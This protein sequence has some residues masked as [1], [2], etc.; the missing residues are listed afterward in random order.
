[1]SQFVTYEQTKYAAIRL[2]SQGP[3][4][5]GTAF[6]FIAGWSKL[7]TTLSTYPLQVIQNRLR[8]FKSKVNGDGDRSSLMK[9]TMACV[10]EILG[11]G[12]APAMYKGITSKLVQSVLTVRNP[13]SL[14]CHVVPPGRA[15]VSAV[16]WP[17]LVALWCR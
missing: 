15:I 12:G 16:C 1:M 17:R 11:E 13:A 5:S 9:D 4:L 8:N 14:R 2:L 6:F 10:N 3:D 7:V